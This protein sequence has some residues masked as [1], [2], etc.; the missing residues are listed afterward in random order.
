MAHALHVIGEY[1][2]M[3]GQLGR[4]LARWYARAVSAAC[5]ESLLPW[6]GASRRRTKRPCWASVRRCRA[7]WD[8]RIGRWALE[9]LI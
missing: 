6:A 9:G 2:E 7:A 1:D 4:L 8:G 5:S 3:E